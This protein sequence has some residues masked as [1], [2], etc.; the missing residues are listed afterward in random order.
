[1]FCPSLP[2][3]A[4]ALL[5]A[6]APAP[7]APAAAAAAKTEKAPPAAPARKARLEN[8]LAAQTKLIAELRAKPEKFDLRTDKPGAQL[9]FDAVGTCQTEERLGALGDGGKW[10]CNAYKLVAQGKHCLV[11]GVGAGKEISFEEAVAAL[12]CEVHVFDPSEHAIKKF[13]ELAKTRKVGAGSITFHPWGLGPVSRDPAKAFDL[14]LDEKPV[15]VRTLDAIAKA[16]GHD[17]VDLLKIDIEGS[18]W[19]T[20]DDVFKKDLLAQ[21]KVTQVLL[22]TH[23]LWGATPKDLIDLIDGFAARGYVMFR[24]EFNPW[25]TGCCA[26][27]AFAQKN[28]LLE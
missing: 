17:H 4:A 3:L 7:K 25:N 21:L 9:I 15:E 19:A 8:G 22:E 20:F 1:M 24:K 12:G 18:E 2:V 16:L 11:Y 10:V 27:Y 13:G 26:E 5:A 23:I 14:K 28:F 6:A